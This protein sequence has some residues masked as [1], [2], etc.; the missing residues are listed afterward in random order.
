MRLLT[1]IVVFTL[2]W[3]CLAPT[4]DA[5]ETNAASKTPTINFVP[6]DDPDS[7]EGEDPPPAGG[8]TNPDGGGDPPPAS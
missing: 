3:L 4:I 6:R 8:E 5:A 1:G 2:T 7:V